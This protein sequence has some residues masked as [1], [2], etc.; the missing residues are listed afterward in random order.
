M[1][2]T[3]LKAILRTAVVAAGMAT[4]LATSMMPAN[5]AGAVVFT[6]TADIACFGCGTSSGT[7][8]LTGVGVTTGGGAVN[9]SAHASYTVQEDAGVNCVITG[10]ASGTVTGSVN[11]SFN[12]TR[13]GAVAV[14][15]TTG[16]IN[17][18][19]VAAFVVTS[20][21]GLPCGAH[22]SATVVGAVAGA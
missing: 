13:V 2:R 20:P 7:A 14:I 10:T 21:V 22:V 5:A 11:V 16:D 17:G 3:A 6:G 12:W 8:E 15:S 19:G 9:G 4:A 18:A 1:R